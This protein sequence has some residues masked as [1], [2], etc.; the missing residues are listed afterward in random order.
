[1][2]N[3]IYS[4]KNR[5]YPDSY[6]DFVASAIANN[7]EVNVLNSKAS[8]ATSSGGNTVGIFHSFDCQYL[9][10]DFGSVIFTGEDAA[11]NYSEW[12]LDYPEAACS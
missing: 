7:Y 6:D 2:S 5:I 1:M 8:I 11:N 12:V 10:D 4:Y 9:D 3:T